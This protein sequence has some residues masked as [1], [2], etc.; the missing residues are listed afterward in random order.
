MKAKAWAGTNDYFHKI[1]QVSGE[2]DF[3]YSPEDAEVWKAPKESVEFA[4]RASKKMALRGIQE[5]YNLKP[6]M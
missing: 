1:W 3:R 6:R 4:S 2:K 5:V